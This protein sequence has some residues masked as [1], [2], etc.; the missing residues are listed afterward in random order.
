M[1]R[2]EV[3][4]VHRDDLMEDLTGWSILVHGKG[5][6]QRLVPIPDELAEAIAEFCPHGGYLFPGN[7]DGHLSAHYV[8][9]LV[10]DLMPPGWSMH[11]LRHRYATKGLAAT[12]DLLAVRDA[13]GHASVATTQ[14]YTKVVGDKV[15]RVSEAA[16]K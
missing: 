10:G 9:K 15:R 4:V 12:G 11:K 2:A 5:G 1:R 14:L 7:D 13:L 16:A 3:A 6:T 8:G